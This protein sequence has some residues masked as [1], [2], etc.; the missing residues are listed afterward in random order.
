MA[1]HWRGDHHG[2]EKMGFIYKWRKQQVAPSIK[3]PFDWIKVNID[4]TS[5][6]YPGDAGVGGILR[7]HLGEILKLAGSTSI[8]MMRWINL[9]WIKLKR[10]SLSKGNPGPV[11]NGGVMYDCNGNLIMAFHDFI[12]ESTNMLA[13]LKC[14]IPWS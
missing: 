10:N 3:P 9:G 12:G 2:A 11:R 4:G 14:I 1:K 13:E 7:N 8:H 5:R 6:G